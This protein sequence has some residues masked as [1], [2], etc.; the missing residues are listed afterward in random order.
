VVLFKDGRKLDVDGRAAGEVLNWLSSDE[1]LWRK[2]LAAWAAD[3]AG[4]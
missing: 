3:N 1:D 2:Q 4:Q